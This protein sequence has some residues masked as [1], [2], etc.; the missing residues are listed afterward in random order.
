VNT[1]K[2]SVESFKQW[3]AE[4]K[5]QLTPVPWCPEGFFVDRDD[6]REALG[7]DL[8]HLLGH[9]YMQEAASMLPVALLDPQPGE[10]VLDMSAAPGSKTTQIAARMQGR[11]VIV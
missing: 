10:A 7:K 5:W 3:A 8:L 11:G 1:L 9:A 4:K 6:R 2:T